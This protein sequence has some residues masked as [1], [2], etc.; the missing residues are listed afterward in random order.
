MLVALLVLARL[1]LTLA[2]GSVICAAVG[3][4]FR[5]LWSVLLLRMSGAI[6]LMLLYSSA[7]LVVVAEVT[8]FPFVAIHVST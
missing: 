1:L 8:V 6:R 2:V 3:K 5:S 4:H 7:L